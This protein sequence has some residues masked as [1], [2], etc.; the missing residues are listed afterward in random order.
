MNDY[1]KS[2]I[3]M[4]DIDGCFLI[5]INTFP[6]F[7]K[8]IEK[9][10]YELYKNNLPFPIRIVLLRENKFLVIW[11]NSIGLEI[12]FSNHVE[13]YW[14]YPTYNIF[15]FALEYRFIITK[16]ILNVFEGKH[17]GEKEA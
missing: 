8:I 16:Q 14:Y 2:L 9:I 1:Y 7:L 5:T 3:I 12:S 11:N 13:Y 15:P 4:K 6:K 17:L 10:Y